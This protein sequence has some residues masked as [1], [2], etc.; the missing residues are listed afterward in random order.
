MVFQAHNVATRVQAL[1]LY[2]EG[3]AVKC[4]M[5]ITGLSRSTIYDL[6]KKARER[7]YDP[8]VSHVILLKYVEDAPRSGRPRKATE[9]KTAG[10]LD[11]VRKDRTGRE[12]STQELG[13]LIGV[14]AR[15]AH[16]ILR[17]AGLIK[18]KLTWKPGLTPAM[19][20]GTSIGLWRT[21]RM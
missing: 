19:H 21:G 9:E 10:L 20:S 17:N 14:S 5:E 13:E 4:I 18:R 6:R 11:H 2:E 3:I 8:T 15:T 7:G 16:W 12:K 1:A